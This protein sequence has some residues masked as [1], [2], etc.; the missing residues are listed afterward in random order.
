MSSHKCENWG[1][2]LTRHLLVNK[3]MWS[4]CLLVNGTRPKAVFSSLVW[5]PEFVKINLTLES[6][7]N[8]HIATTSCKWAPLVSDHFLKNCFASQ[9]N[10]FFKNSLTSDHCSNFSHNLNHFLGKKSDIFFCFLCHVWSREN[11]SSNVT[12]FSFYGADR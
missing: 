10:T 4:F 2:K 7:V 5:R 12:E 3:T 9:W 6:T 11:N 8:S 1:T